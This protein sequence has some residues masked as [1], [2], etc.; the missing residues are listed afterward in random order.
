MLQ[1]SHKQRKR[2]TCYSLPPLSRARLRLLAMQ[3]SSD[4]AEVAASSCSAIHSA[5]SSES[6]TG[7]AASGDRNRRRDA[8]S[9]SD[10]TVDLLASNLVEFWSWRRRGVDEEASRQQRRGPWRPGGGVSRLAAATR[11][12]GH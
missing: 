7:Q 10:P 9:S 8:A 6:I 11:S 1:M 5:S 4:A 2:H 12:A 3:A